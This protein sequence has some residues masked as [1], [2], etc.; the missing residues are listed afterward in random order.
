VV[1]DDVVDLPLL[2]QAGLGVAVADAYPEV[3]RQAHRCTLLP[4]GRGAV[5]EVCDWLVNA[6]RSRSPVGP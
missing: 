5:R 1:G 3:R 6:R 4:G 2:K